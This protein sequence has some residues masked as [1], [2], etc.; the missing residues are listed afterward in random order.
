VN[1]IEPPGRRVNAS[2]NLFYIIPTDR[3]HYTVRDQS[4]L[5]GGYFT[6]RVD[7]RKYALSENGNK[8][9]L[10]VELPSSISPLFRDVVAIVAGSDDASN[11]QGRRR[12]A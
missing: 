1:S 4:F 5:H 11:V 2:I 12:Q 6:N 10:V 3:G 9:D 8:P 7:A